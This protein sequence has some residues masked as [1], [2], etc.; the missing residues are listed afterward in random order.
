MKL[1]THCGGRV[2]SFLPSANRLRVEFSE[3][4]L[5]NS[6]SFL[7]IFQISM[8]L[9]LSFALLSLLGCSSAYL[10][11]IDANEEQCF[12]DRVISG[13]WSFCLCQAYRELISDASCG[14]ALIQKF[15]SKHNCESPLNQF[16]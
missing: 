15:L 16:L 13:R 4:C 7:Y 5:Q 9:L 10:I 2:I 12:F 11:H 3:L 8:K 6:T 1:C 14:L